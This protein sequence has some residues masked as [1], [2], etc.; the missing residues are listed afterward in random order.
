MLKAFVKAAR[1]RTLPLAIGSIAMGSALASFFYQH[2]W[3]ITWLA[4]LTAILLQILSNFANDYGDFK[5][6]TD[7]K[8]RTDRALA[9]GGLSEKQMKN[10]LIVT[11][12][13]STVV[14]VWLLFSAFK[15]INL[16]FIIW[17]FIG[18]MAIAAAIK[19]TAGK[20]AYGYRALGDLAVYLFFGLVAV[21]GVYVLHTNDLGR[22][23]YVS[24]LPASAVG[25]MATGILNINNIR[26][27][28]GDK[29]NGK[30]TL[31]V[32]LKK[33]NAEV[34]QLILYVLSFG[35]M[36][37]FFDK[38]SGRV[39][40]LFLLLVIPYFVLWLRLKSLSN[41]GTMRPTYNK[42]LKINV[43]LNLVWVAV[44]CFLLLF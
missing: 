39:S 31:A 41:N 23:F 34:Y 36:Y 3:K 26:D 5:K 9:S 29:A 37:L 15:N 25:L 28:E 21:L 18:F 17:L 10:A 8:T 6:G 38:T 4:T 42:L 12:V 44:C 27:I 33:R 43:L 1:L 13:L 7:D 40:F 30:I 32:L 14:G 2:S 35:L 24:I 19:Y 11:A 22:N 20:S 16:S